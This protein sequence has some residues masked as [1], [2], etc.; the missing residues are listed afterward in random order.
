MM[1]DV[2][3]LAWKTENMPAH[4]F[5]YGHRA[6]LLEKGSWPHQEIRRLTQHDLPP[7]KPC[8]VC[9]KVLLSNDSPPRNEAGQDAE[10]GSQ[11]EGRGSGGSSWE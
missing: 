10:P 1:R 7:P 4:S 2:V 8:D 6:C 5:A 9:G 3:C 11:Q